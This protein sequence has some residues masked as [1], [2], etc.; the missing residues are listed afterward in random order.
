[1]KK[2]QLIL[3][4]LTFLFQGCLFDCKDYLNEEIKPRHIYGEVIAKDNEETGCFGTIILRN[5]HT[6][7]TLSG[8]C[9]CVPESEN[10]WAYMAIGD[11]LLKPKGE[12]QIKVISKGIIRS[13]QYPCC[14]H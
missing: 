14:N 9:Y 12:L 10:A 6:N 13:F 1:M 3:F 7:D 2:I 11:T 4:V 8:F 5:K